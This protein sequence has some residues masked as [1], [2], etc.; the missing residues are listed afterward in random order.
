MNPIH[1]PKPYFP[2]IH[3][4]VVL[5][6]TSRSSVFNLCFTIPVLLRPC[7]GH[8]ERSFVTKT[9]DDG[10]YFTSL[11][12]NCTWYENT[13]Q[14]TVLVSEWLAGVGWGN[15]V[16]RCSVDDRTYENVLHLTLLICKP[17]QACPTLGLRNTHCLLWCWK[18]QRDK[19]TGICTLFRNACRAVSYMKM[20]RLQNRQT[21]NVT[22]FLWVWNLVSYSKRTQARCFLIIRL[23]SIGDEYKLRK[24]SLCGFRSPF[25]FLYRC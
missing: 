8:C 23:H 13:R 11:P 5:P 16:D 17:D 14:P 22:C 2:K 7:S 15:Q 9:Q 18:P 19:I 1:I 12:S 10:Y 21:C 4:N 25:F 3:L 6:S 24:S 20:K